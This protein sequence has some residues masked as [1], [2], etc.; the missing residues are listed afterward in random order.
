VVDG[1]AFVSPDDGMEGGGGD[2]IVGIRFWDG[3]VLGV[4]C[5]WVGCHKWLVFCTVHASVLV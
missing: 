1:V 3:N 4:L 5:A 2:R